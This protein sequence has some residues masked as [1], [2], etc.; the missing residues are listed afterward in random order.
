[1][2]WCWLLLCVVCNSLGEYCSKRYVADT[3]FPRWVVL[4]V[5]AYMAGTL[6]WLPLLRANGNRLALSGTLWSL[7]TAAASLAVAVGIFGERL[8]LSQWLGVGLALLAARL[9][10]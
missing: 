6:F 8:T 2:L 9:L 4:M 1:M 7:S 3:Q 5:A 10:Q